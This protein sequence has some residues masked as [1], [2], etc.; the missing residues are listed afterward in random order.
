MKVR[1]GVLSLALLA[2]VAL[3]GQSVVVRHD[4]N[5]QAYRDLA[6]KPE[7]LAGNLAIK[8]ARGP[9][10][11]VVI[12]KQYVLTAGHPIEGYDLAEKGEGA[13]PA[14]VV[15][16]KLQGKEYEADYYYLYPGYQR[17][18]HDPPELKR[19]FPLGDIAIIRLTA[20]VDPRV[21]PASIWLGGVVF[22]EIFTC[23]GQGKSGTGLQRDEPLPEG[24]VRG[25]TNRIDY[26]DLK[27][28]GMM[29]RSD[30]DDGSEAANTLNQT[31]Y[32]EEA[33]QA[34]GSSP[35]P[36]PLEGTGAAGDSGAGAWVQRNNAWT[37][38]GDFSFRYYS[39]YGGQSGFTNLSSPR[40]AAWIRELNTKLDKPF[41]IASDTPT[42]PIPR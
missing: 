39:G 8:D 10:S 4:V 31:V 32:G 7:F 15:K 40:V 5:E 28:D 29:F 12:G 11:G 20:P 36:T 14:H 1:H 37:L 21:K 23:V 22:Q 18:A 6:A 30:F 3:P 19:P 41:E 2:L 35:I 25:F 27:R 33:A 13:L 9:W 34:Q 24:T 38:A 26:L 16:V 42:K 17:V